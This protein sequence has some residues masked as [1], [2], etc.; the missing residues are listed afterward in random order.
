M[1]RSTATLLFAACLIGHAASALADAR[2]MS[3]R[4]QYRLHRAAATCCVDPADFE[5]KDTTLPGQS[6]FDI[7]PSSRLFDFHSGRSFFAALRLPDTSDSYRIRV[8]SLLQGKGDATRVFY[9]VVA[10]LNEDFIVTRISSV[11]HLR[12][13]AG[14]ATPGGAAGLALTIRVDPPLAHERY[15]VVFTPAV[16]LGAAP[17][18][19]READMLTEAAAE[20]FESKGDA[21]IQPAVFGLLQVS[22]VPD[23]GGAASDGEGG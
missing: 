3:D 6:T 18:E 15:L 16:L 19:R 8:K 14:L 11:A 12:L 13:E 22:L 23:A 2:Q 10:L 4:A 7:G 21:A 5:Y 9:P 1:T 17:A 20:Y